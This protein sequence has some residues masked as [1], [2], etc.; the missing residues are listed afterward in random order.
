LV[1]EKI[2]MQGALIDVWLKFIKCIDNYT[3]K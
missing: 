2:E 1:K 3:T